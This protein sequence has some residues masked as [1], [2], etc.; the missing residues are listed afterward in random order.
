MPNTLSFPYRVAGS[1][2]ATAIQ[3]SDTY[4]KEQLAVILQT[5]QKERE[6]L[7]EFGMPD[8]AF[9]GFLYSAFDYQVKTYLPGITKASARI[10]NQTDQGVQSIEIT[11]ESGT[12]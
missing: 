8:M 4:Y 3:G 10:T 7:P 12:K 9:E 6:H 1:R 2:A 5:L 11:F